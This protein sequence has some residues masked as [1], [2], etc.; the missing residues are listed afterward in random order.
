MLSKENQTLLKDCVLLWLATTDSQNQPNVSPKEM[1]LIW[2][3]NTI[4]VANIASPQTVKNIKTNPKICLSA[5]NIFTQKGLK[6]NGSAEI[7]TKENEDFTEMESRIIEKYS[8]KFSFKEIIVISIEKV[9]PILAPSY[10]FFKE[11]T[12]ETQIKSA[13]ETYKVEEI[14]KNQ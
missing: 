4:I 14:L 13:F 2:D 10:Q 3:E 6:I 12:E 1:F 9:V 8:E 5:I 7:Y 11:T